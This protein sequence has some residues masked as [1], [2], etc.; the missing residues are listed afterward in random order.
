MLSCVQQISQVYILNK[1]D[2]SKIRTSKIGLEETERLSNISLNSNPSPWKKDIKKAVKIIA[3]NCAGLKEHFKDIKTGSTLQMGDIIN[4]I[5]TSLEKCEEDLFTLEG[6]KAHHVTMG[7]GK[8][9][10]TYYKANIF[11]H[12]DDFIKTDMQITKF[13]TENLDMNM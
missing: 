11:Q 3:L 10:T 12:K 6:Y 13:S 2:E 5:E 4:L 9:I 7:K 8:G 1:L